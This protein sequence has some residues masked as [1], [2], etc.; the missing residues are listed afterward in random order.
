MRESVIYQEIYQE[1]NIKGKLEGKL[2]GIQ[3]G[4]Q[5]GLQQGLQLGEI[6][7]MMRQLTRRFGNLNQNIQTQIDNLSLTKL[8]DLGESLLDFQS[9]NDLISWLNNNSN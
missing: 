5:Q 8:E 9:I 1:G 4:L 7:L 3:E 6:T 2:E